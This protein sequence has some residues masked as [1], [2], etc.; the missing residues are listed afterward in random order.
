MR[1]RADRSDLRLLWIVR[2]SINLD[3]EIA[4]GA[5]ELG[6][7]EKKLDRPQV[8]RALVY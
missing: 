4:T 1:H 5:L 3:A 8:S 7:A 2:A 6:V